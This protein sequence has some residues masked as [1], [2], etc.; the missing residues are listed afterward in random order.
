LVH[1]VF[2]A[3]EIKVPVRCHLAVE[4]E[5]KCVF[6]LV[7]AGKGFCLATTFRSLAM[8]NL[9]SFENYVSWR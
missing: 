1:F 3:V 7:M 5:R 6:I 8:D 9:S 2:F 4:Q